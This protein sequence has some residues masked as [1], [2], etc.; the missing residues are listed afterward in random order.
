MWPRR[1]RAEATGFVDL[2]THV[3]PGLDDGACSLEEAELLCQLAADD[4]C[5]TLV[6]T[7]HHGHPLFATHS[8][9]RV[10]EALLQLRGR[11]AARIQVLAGAEVH[12]TRE[13]DE[14]LLSDGQL[15]I[16][17][18]AGSDVVLLEFPPEPY[19]IDAAMTVHEL[20]VRGYRPLIAHPELIPWL[21]NDL[22]LLRHLA[23]RGALLQVTAGCL[24][25]ELGH[26]TR[27]LVRELISEGLV[28]VLAS[29]MHSPGE[30]GPR[31]RAAHLE[32]SRLWNEDLARLLTIDRP[33]SLL[34]RRGQTSGPRIETMEAS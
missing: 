7:P 19:G 6:A 28:H 30:R 34:Q 14:Q 2:H 20:L 1:Q 27:R 21:A 31:L 17:T 22:D 29:D 5:V 33:A 11:V 9:S 26:P 13:M 4:G 15:Q 16:P 24:L 18:L 25:A 32:V 8:R 3:L 12:W 10:N 23:R